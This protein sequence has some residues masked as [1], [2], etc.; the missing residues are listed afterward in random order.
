MWLLGCLVLPSPI[1]L[2]PV[3]QQLVCRLH[4]HTT[5]I[6]DKVST[7]G[8]T[9]NVAF[10]TFSGILSTKRKHVTAMTTPIRTQICEGFE[11]VRN[12][13][14]NLFFVSILKP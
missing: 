3:I 14:I 1:D 7:I 13:V 10:R 2:P 11:T 9:C 5:E 4:R 6:G 12:P 8:M